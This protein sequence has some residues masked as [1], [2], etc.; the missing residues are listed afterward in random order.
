MM[1]GE[2]MT[3]R[4]DLSDLLSSRKE[5]LGKSYRELEAACFDP[6]DR[7]SGPLWK[8]G[9]LENL[10]KRGST[11]P[12]TFAHLKALAHG[13]ELPLGQVQEAAGA[14]FFGIDTVWAE[15]DSVRALVH[16]FRGMSP[17]DQEWVRA[18]V[19]SRRATKG[20]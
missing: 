19:Q 4:T 16:D 2:A 18:I 7:E 17:E 12:P 3:G 14:Q 13:F 9:T 11:K 5:A 20:H 15:D 1:T 10:L 8:R 6:D